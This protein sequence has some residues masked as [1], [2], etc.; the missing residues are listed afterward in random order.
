[1]LRAGLERRLLVNL[2]KVLNVNKS[3]YGSNK[4]T[5]ELMSSI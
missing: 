2:F 5:S 4:G 3:F 1:M